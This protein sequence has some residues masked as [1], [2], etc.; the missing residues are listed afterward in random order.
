MASTDSPL[1][2]LVSTFIEDFATWLLR[3]EVQVAQPLNAELPAETQVADQ[4]FHVTQ[5]D[6]QDIIL[7]LEFQGRRS[8]QPM[9]WRMLEYMTRLASTHRRD[10]YSVVLYV[11]QGAGLNDTGKHQ[12]NGP[13]G[14]VT[15]SWQYEVIRL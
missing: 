1:K 7:H 12:V 8:H 3:S 9:R 10:L 13:A 15:L 5:Q 11:G 6:G 4:V 14:I 2:R